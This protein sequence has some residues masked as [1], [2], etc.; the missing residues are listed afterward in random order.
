MSLC[1]ITA[2]IYNF[3]AN[4]LCLV[5]VEETFWGL[6]TRVA[7]EGQFPSGC[8]GLRHTE[9]PVFVDTHGGGVRV[10]A[11]MGK[12]EVLV[13]RQHLRKRRKKQQDG[14]S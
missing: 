4:C 14:L 1:E 12:Q 13:T 5:L 8:V 3:A 2:H 6:H 9:V 10:P 7:A 11:G